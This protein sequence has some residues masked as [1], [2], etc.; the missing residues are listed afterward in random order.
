MKSISFAALCLLGLVKAD[1]PVHCVRDKL[2]GEWYFHVNSDDTTVN[3]YQTRDLCTH[4]VPN[5]I[6]LVN[7]EHKF[8]FQKEDVY[9]I[10]LLEN[11]KAEAVV[12]TSNKPLKANEKPSN[13]GKELI[14]GRWTA[15]YDQALN[16]ELDNGQR[17][18]ANLR[19]N[20][21]HAVA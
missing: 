5:K 2:F 3:L 17:F 19:Y 7:A 9:K 10:N 6:Q 1:Q 16:I 14:K 15:V 21:K 13:C 18:L 20:L 4:A 11:F 8:Y 12:C